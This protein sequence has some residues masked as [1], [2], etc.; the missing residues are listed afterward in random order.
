MYNYL[1][2]QWIM[3]RV[4]AEYI[5]DRVPKFI[6]AE[7]CAVILETPQTPGTLAITNLV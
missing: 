6:T 1:L 3:A 7:Q 4:S 5:Q 2:K